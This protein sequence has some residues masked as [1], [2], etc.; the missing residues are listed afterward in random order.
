[1]CRYDTGVIG[2]VKVMKDW[3]RTFGSPSTDLDKHPTG[4]AITSS[5]ESLIVSILSAGTFVGTSTIRV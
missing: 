3:L 5:Q 1:M 2:G 4:Y